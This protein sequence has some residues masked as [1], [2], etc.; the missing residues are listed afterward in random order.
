MELGAAV[1]ACLVSAWTIF[2][3]VCPD[4]DRNLRVIRGLYGFYLY[5]HEFWVDYLLSIGAS[6]LNFGSESKLCGMLVTLNEAL[7]VYPSTAEVDILDNVVL[8]ERIQ[9]L[10]PF[11]QLHRSAIAILRARRTRANETLT[12][13]VQGWYL[14]YPESLLRLTTAPTDDTQNLVTVTDFKKLFSNYQ[15]IIRLLLDGREVPGASFE[16]LQ[17]FKAQ[18]KNS[19]YTCRVHGCPRATLGFETDGLRIEHEQGHVQVFPCRFPDCQ[20]PSPT[21]AAALRRHISKHHD[22]INRPL[23]IRK[24]KAGG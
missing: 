10:Q 14:D 2:N 3:P 13:E 7:D 15:I 23:R 19:A 20:H 24:P 1:V 5:A 6:N 4:L 22:D 12:I 11:C 18:F 8:D 17:R 9:C 21:S 16:E